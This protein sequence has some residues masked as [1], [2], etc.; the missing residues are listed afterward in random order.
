M[1]EKWLGILPKV[2]TSTS[3]SGSCTC[4]FILRHGTDGFTSAPKEGMLRI[5]FARKIRRLR[6]GLNPRAWVP[7]ASTLREDNIKTNILMC[8]LD[9]DQVLLIR[10]CKIQSL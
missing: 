1:C 6:S 7:K 4:P 8:T 9:E 2:A 3:L 10:P 5:F